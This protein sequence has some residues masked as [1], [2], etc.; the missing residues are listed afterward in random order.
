MTID[1]KREILNEF[2][3]HSKCDNCKLIADDWKESVDTGDC[4]KK[5]IYIRYAPEEDLDRAI[6]IVMGK[7]DT[8]VN[9]TLSFNH[10]G[11]L[12]GVYPNMNV[13]Y[14]VDV[15]QDEDGLSV[16]AHKIYADDK[17]VEEHTVDPV[18]HPSHYCTGKYECIDVMLETQGVE[19]VKSF[20]VCNAF[21]Y[22]YRHNGKNA[23]EDIKKAKW[24]LDKY[25][26]LEEGDLI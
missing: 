10:D 6:D 26:E 1:E 16:I 21:K 4:T 13:K 22:L 15:E 12:D 19:A 17:V 8:P 11:I 5:C 3:K 9:F 18:N 14:D 23:L 25:I 7:N 2:C 24:Y 20:C